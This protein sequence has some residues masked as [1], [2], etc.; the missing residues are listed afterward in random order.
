MLEITEKCINEIKNY[1]KNTNGKIAII[2]I[3][4]GK[5][6]SVAAA[7][8]VNALGKE[9]VIGI[10]MPNKQQSDIN[11]SIKLC[12]HLKIKYFNM[13]IFNS[14]NAIFTNLTNNGIE[15]SEQTK[16][17]LQP[18]I[19]MTTLYAVAQSFDGGR[20][21]NTTNMCEAFVGYG[22]LWG[23]TVGDFAP[24]KNLV[25]SEIKMIGRDLGLPI[26]LIVKTPTDG[27]SGKSDEEKLGVT[28]DE[29][30]L[31]CKEYRNIGWKW[32]YINMRDVLNKKSFERIL[33]LY[34]KSKFKRDM[35]DIP[36]IRIGD[37]IL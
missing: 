10:L 20:V 36:T 26:E 28:Y 1:F 23:D 4:G 12:E 15:P 17:N 8:C 22:T 31:W 32:S 16:I 18:R 35:I 21:I 3:S 13:D 14:Y 24:L 34:N 11:D 9:N 27:L 33:D 30:E 6:S 37:C 25:I 5:D 29:I 7:M 2:G 19:R